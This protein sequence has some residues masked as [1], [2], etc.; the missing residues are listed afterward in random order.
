MK[1][2]QFIWWPRDWHLMSGRFHDG[3]RLV[4]EWWIWLGPL[5]IRKWRKQ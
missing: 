5:E 2:Y 3:L 1:K 4:Y